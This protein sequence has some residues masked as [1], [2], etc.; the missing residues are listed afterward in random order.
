MGGDQRLYF[1]P[2]SY[3]QQTLKLPHL[4]KFMIKISKSKHSILYVCLWIWVPLLTFFLNETDF[5]TLQSK[6]LHIP[7]VLSLLCRFGVRPQTSGYVHPFYPFENSC[8]YRL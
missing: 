1:H 5:S 6:T 7:L 3:Y 8:V 2:S 4:G